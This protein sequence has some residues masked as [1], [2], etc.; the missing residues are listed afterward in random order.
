MDETQ[1]KALLEGFKSDILGEVKNAM[2]ETLTAVDKKNS[3]TAASLTK[4]FQKSTKEILAQVRGGSAGEEPEPTPSDDPEPSP[5]PKNTERLTLKALKQEIESLR[6][7][8]EAKEQQLAI[9]N[10]NSKL[11]KILKENKVNYEDRATK[12]FLVDYGDNLKSEDGTWYVAEGEDVV[13][14]DD[15]VKKFLSTDYGSTFLQPSKGKGMGLKP[16]NT[17]TPPGG[18][19]GEPTLNTSLF[20]VEE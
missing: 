5:S 9:T 17:V 15:A 19:A 10:R 18:K 20:A 4:E 8:N 11:S 6:Q 2:S 3:G 12:A 13:S 16:A 14:L 7:A 1:L